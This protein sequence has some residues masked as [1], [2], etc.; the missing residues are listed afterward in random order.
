MKFRKIKNWVPGSKGVLCSPPTDRHT[1]DKHMKVEK[2]RTLKGVDKPVHRD[3]LYHV[4]YNLNI[5]M[6]I[7]QYYFYIH[8]SNQSYSLVARRSLSAL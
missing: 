8:V 3:C 4:A 2:Q 5:P 7:E 1:D 6:P